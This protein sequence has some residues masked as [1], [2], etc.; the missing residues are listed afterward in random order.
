M[1][2]GYSD[3]PVGAIL[4]HRGEHYQVVASPDPTSCG[5]CVF[6][7]KGCQDFECSGCFREDGKEVIFKKVDSQPKTTRTPCMGWRISTKY[8]ILE[9]APDVEQGTCKGC[10]F[11]NIKSPACEFLKDSSGIGSCSSEDITRN[12]VGQSFIFKKIGERKVRPPELQKV[13][14]ITD[15]VD[16]VDMTS[17]I[18]R[19]ALNV[20]KEI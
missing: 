1:S 10:F 5:E 14:W 2:K 4:E 3:I 18:Y 13:T 7:G 20:L 9:I 11:D 19:R 12:P 17:S 15:T 6:K 16:E 8:G